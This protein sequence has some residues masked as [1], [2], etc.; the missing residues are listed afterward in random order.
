MRGFDDLLVRQLPYLDTITR[1]RL[2]LQALAFADALTEECIPMR[3]WEFGLCFG[4]LPRLRLISAESIVARVG[5]TLK[6]SCAGF[7]NLQ[8]VLRYPWGFFREGGGDDMYADFMAHLVLNSLHQLNT[9]HQPAEG[10]RERLTR[11][12][13]AFFAGHP[14]REE[15]TL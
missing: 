3:R 6:I 15:L 4:E 2:F 1:T 13:L 14:R 8:R 9:D 7:T 12:I 5:E 10:M 11:D